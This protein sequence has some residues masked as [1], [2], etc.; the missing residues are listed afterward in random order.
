MSQKAAMNNPAAVSS[1]KCL[2]CGLTNFADTKQCRR[3]KADPFLPLSAAKDDNPMRA[4]AGEVG[5]SRF[6]LAW[7]LAAIAVVLLGLVVFYMRQGPPVTL[8]ATSEVGALPVA[9]GAEQPAADPAEENSRSEA[10]ATH[11]L[12]KLK[13]FQNETERG[14]EFSAYEEKLNQLKGELDR[15]LPG[16]VRHEPEDETFRQEIAAAVRDHTAAVNWW[17]TTI[18]NS[19]VLTEA[20]RN[21]RTQVKWE[22][23]R[24]HLSKAEKMLA[25]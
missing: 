18:R 4:D 14:M 8:A 11:V 10:V 20:D 19:S 7:I 25:R 2:H 15:A 13:S 16:F 23:A 5:R 6:S 21:E 12:A 22:S 17:K 24:T 3:C 1:K 9:A